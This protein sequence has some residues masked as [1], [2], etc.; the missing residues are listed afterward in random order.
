LGRDPEPRCPYCGS[1]S[2]VNES[3]LSL[4][5]RASERIARYVV[6]ERDKVD[7]DDPLFRPSFGEVGVC[8]ETSRRIWAC[9]YCRSLIPEPEPDGM[10]AR[11]PECGREANVAPSRRKIV[12]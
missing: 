4:F 11:C 7:D 12:C 8:R 3:A 1:P 5:L 9:P 2:C 10:T 6:K